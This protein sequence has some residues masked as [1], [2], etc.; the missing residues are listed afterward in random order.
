MTH[1]ADLASSELLAPAR[2]GPLVGDAGLLERLLDGTGA[3]SAG[4]LGDGVRGKDEV[5]V[6]EGLAGDTGAVDERTVVVND[7]GND[8]K[9]AGRGAV[10]DKDNTANL[11]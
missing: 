7:L 10:V 11:L 6:G 1:L 2:S 3:S 8:R 9:L 5:A 4:E